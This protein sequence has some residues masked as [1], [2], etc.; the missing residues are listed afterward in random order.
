MNGEATLLTALVGDE[1]EW[2]DVV[3][4]FRKLKKVREAPAGVIVW[5]PIFVSA[6]AR[7]MDSA[8]KDWLRQPLGPV[9]VNGW[10]TFQKLRKYRDPAQYPPEKTYTECLSKHF[11]RLV[12]KPTIEVFVNRIRTAIECEVR[13]TFVLEAAAL[14]IRGGRIYEVGLGKCRAEGKLVCE[15][16]EL[17]EPRSRDLQLPE[18][19]TFSEGIPIP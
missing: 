4:T 8:L 15:G 11:I 17:L 10:N 6:L 16:L 19:F 3:S 2:P 1:S 7:R 14:Q 12:Q 13:L 18:L 5:L 9:L